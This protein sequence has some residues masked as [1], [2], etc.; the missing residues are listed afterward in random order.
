MADLA[1]LDRVPQVHD[2][3]PRAG[4]ERA[5]G[6]EGDRGPKSTRTILFVYAN[7]TKLIGKQFRIRSLYGGDADHAS[8][9][10]TWAYFK[11]TR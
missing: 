3:R 10:S 9:E 1:P 7:S 11:I 6:G 4:R 8:N 2:A 5:V